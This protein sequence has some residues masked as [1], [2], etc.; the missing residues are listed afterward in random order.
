M[1]VIPIRRDF[2]VHPFAPIE[3]VWWRNDDG[4]IFVFSSCRQT[5]GRVD[6]ARLSIMQKEPLTDVPGGSRL[7]PVLSCGLHQHLLQQIS[8]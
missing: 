2:I 7:H 3:V 6:S 8:L 1:R 5:K 4:L